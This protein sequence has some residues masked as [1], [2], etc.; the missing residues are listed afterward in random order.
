[1]SRMHNDLALGHGIVASMPKA[2]IQWA[3][4]CNMLQFAQTMSQLGRVLGFSNLRVQSST[5]LGEVG[6]LTASDLQRRPKAL[7]HIPLIYARHRAYLQTEPI[8]PNHHILENS[9]S[10]KIAAL[11][12]MADG[13]TRTF[14]NKSWAMPSRL[15]TWISARVFDMLQRVSTLCTWVLAHNVCSLM[16]S[17]PSPCKHQSCEE[18]N[19]QVL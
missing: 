10:P 6:W 1:M 13:P 9:R 19:C 17:H 3:R 14:P 2:G 4:G 15:F 8:Q 7:T 18:S 16:L 12:G 11:H 5:R